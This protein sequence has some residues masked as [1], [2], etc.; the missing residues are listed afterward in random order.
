MPGLGYV[1]RITSHD[2][3]HLEGVGNNPI[4]GGLMITMVIN[5]LRPS[6]DD[7]PSTPSN[8]MT[9]CQ[10]DRVEPKLP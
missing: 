10:C 1:V 3:G 7:P 9:P 4:L 5:H 6:W 8:A 2:L